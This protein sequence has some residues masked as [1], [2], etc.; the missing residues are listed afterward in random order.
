M[1]IILLTDKDKTGGEI[2][3]V[4]DERA[5]HIIKI[6]KSK[7]GDTIEIGLYNGSLGRAVIEKIEP[8]KVSLKIIQTFPQP[9][10][11][12]SVHLICA[13]PRP[14]TLKKIL[15]HTA[16]MGVKRVDFINSGKVEKSYYQSHLLEKKYYEKIL[17]LGMSQGKQTAA[18]EIYFHKKFKSFFE[19]VYR[20]EA[21]GKTLKLVAENSS[22]KKLFDVYTSAVDY[23]TVAVG[24]EG[25]WIPY[26]I[27][28][29]EN[30]GFVPFTL[31][32]WILRVEAAVISVL[33]QIELLSNKM[34]K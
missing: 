14:Q 33:S 24:P 18:P 29:M 30:L 22:G 26:E 7:P 17:L 10:N 13:L 27:E 23:L 5:K 6:L 2:F 31:G 9:T 15:F 12:P 20:D 1:N 11:F 19:D 25:G 21:D 4:S 3:T 8:G 34:I 28:Y 16:S 32:K